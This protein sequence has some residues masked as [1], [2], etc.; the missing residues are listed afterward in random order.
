LLGGERELESARLIALGFATMA[1]RRS[2]IGN[3]KRPEG[4]A[5][6][7]VQRGVGAQTNRQRQDRGGREG[8]VLRKK[9]QGVSEIAHGV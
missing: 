1:T 7:P 3:I 6:Q 8:L 2:G 4:R 9:P 5:E